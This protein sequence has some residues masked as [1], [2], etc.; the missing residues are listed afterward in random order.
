MERK[1]KEVAR[2]AQPAQHLID[3]QCLCQGAASQKK[4]N[5]RKLYLVT[6]AVL[7]EVAQPIRSQ[8]RPTGQFHPSHLCNCE[9]RS[10][11]CPWLCSFP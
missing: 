8:T 2:Q 4:E 7:L 3:P 5:Q 6:G 11:T 9:S 10:A 1:P